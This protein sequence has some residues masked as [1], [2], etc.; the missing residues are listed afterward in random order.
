LGLAG[1]EDRMPRTLSG[2]QR[3]RVALAR[4]I[5]ARPALLLLDEPF[6]ALDPSLRQEVREATLAAQREFRLSLVIVTHDLDEAGLLGDRVG[7]LL[8]RRLA[9]VASPAELFTRPASPEVARF[10]GMENRVEGVMGSDGIFRSVLG[11][12]VLNSRSPAPGPA[13]AWFHS[14][15]VRASASANG[16]ARVIAVRHRVESA[17][18]V[19][20]VGGVRL[21]VSMD[22]AAP[23]APGGAARLAVDPCRLI[24][25]PAPISPSGRPVAA[26]ERPRV[27]HDYG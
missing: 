14:G 22:T 27:A 5:A 2:G 10:L 23:P 16:P 4:A 26:A 15:T 21:E 25:F 1:F 19:V 3:H 12:V 20:E 9:Q 8:G 18:A 6:A 11:P 13:I 17:T 7:V 24:L